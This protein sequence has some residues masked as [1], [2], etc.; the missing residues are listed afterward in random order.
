MLLSWESEYSVDVHGQIRFRQEN[1]TLPARVIA[2]TCVPPRWSE[3]VRDEK[4]VFQEVSHAGMI[5]IAGV[6]SE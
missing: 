1:F 3:R 2:F 4:Y 5:L 6:Q